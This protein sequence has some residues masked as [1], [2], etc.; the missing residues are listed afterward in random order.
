MVG[1]GVFVC[2][3]KWIVS[4]VYLNSHISYGIYV[5]YTAEKSEM[6]STKALQN[7]GIAPKD[8]YERF[9]MIIFQRIY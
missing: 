2:V 7:N 6:L 4:Y 1:L 5:K 8:L 9:V 3:S